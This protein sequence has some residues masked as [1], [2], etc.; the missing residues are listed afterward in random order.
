MIP[1]SSMGALMALLLV[2]EGCHAMGIGTSESEGTESQDQLEF[3]TLADD[4]LGSPTAG[5]ESHLPSYH[6]APYNEWVDGLLAPFSTD[7]RIKTT[8]GDAIFL[9]AGRA[10]VHKLEDRVIDSQLF[11]ATKTLC[12]RPTPQYSE[13]LNLLRNKNT[14]L[15]ELEKNLDWVVSSSRRE[16]WTVRNQ[17]SSQLICKVLSPALSCYESV[18]AHMV[19]CVSDGRAVRQAVADLDIL[20]GGYCADEASNITRNLVQGPSECVSVG[21]NFFLKYTGPSFLQHLSAQHY[22]SYPCLYT[23]YILSVADVILKK[24]CSASTL[25]DRVAEIEAEFSAKAGCDVIKV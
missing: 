9:S 10:I 12:S 8:Y 3:S 17:V 21:V 25:L 2:V 18:L 20:L 1:S 15:T 16:D 4:S 14:C 13:F 19:D 23:K 24:Y 11:G 5:H 6:A 22:S 7:L